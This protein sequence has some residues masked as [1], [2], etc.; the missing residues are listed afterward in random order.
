MPI[1]RF[2]LSYE[3]I[4]AV[5]QLRDMVL[6]I[7]AIGLRLLATIGWKYAEPTRRKGGG[8]YGMVWW[9]TVHFDSIRD[10][11]SRDLYTVVNLQLWMPRHAISRLANLGYSVRWLTTCVSHD[12]W[13]WLWTLQII[14]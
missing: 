6:G 12:G 13:H 4:T 11:L 7:V 9:P 14:S 2:K 3:L 1:L 10:P 8:Y 5:E